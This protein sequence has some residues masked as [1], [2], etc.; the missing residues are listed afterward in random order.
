MN[1]W[2][3][4]KDE[5]LECMCKVDC[6]DNCGALENPRSFDEYKKAYKHWVG[7]GLS[8]GCSHGC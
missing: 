8:R 5:E 2:Q 1:C 7:H 4:K 3:C 6:D